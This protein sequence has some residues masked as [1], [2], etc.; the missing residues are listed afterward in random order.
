MSRHCGRCVLGNVLSSVDQLASLQK[1]LGVVTIGVFVFRQN[2]IKQDTAIPCH[3]VCCVTLF[4]PKIVVVCFVADLVP[5]TVKQ[6]D[7]FVVFQHFK[8]STAPIR[9]FP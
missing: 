1:S 8:D 2:W 7:V 3:E 9:S 6:E 4:K 5:D